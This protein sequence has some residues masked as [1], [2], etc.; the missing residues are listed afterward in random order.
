MIKGG[1]EL[2]SEGVKEETEVLDLVMRA[3]LRCGQ[4]TS[5]DVLALAKRWT[6]FVRPT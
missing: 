3:A 2:L 6:E 4:E 5:G 1:L